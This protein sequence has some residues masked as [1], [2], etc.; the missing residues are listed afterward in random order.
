MKHGPKN[1]RDH[2]R[3]F[4]QLRAAPDVKECGKD[5]QMVPVRG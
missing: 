1:R 5:Q 2:P 4:Q 3:N